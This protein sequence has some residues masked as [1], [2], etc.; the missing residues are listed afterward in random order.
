M[1]QEKE[2]ERHNQKL[3]SIRNAQTKEEIP[4]ANISAVTRYL[5]N[6]SSFDGNKV[7]PSEFNIVLDAILKYNFF[8][9]PEVKEIYMQVLKK[10]YPDKTQEEYEQ[11]YSQIANSSNISHY[12]IEASERSAKLQEFK[13]Q[14]ELEQHKQN[15]KQIKDAFEIKDLPKGFNVGYSNTYKT[16]TETKI[17]V[18]PC[19]YMDGIN[20][21]NNRDMF[22]TIDKLRYIVRDIKDFFKKQKIYIKIKDK[23][24]EIIGRIGTYHIICNIS[25]SD[26]K[27]GN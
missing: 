11:K 15:M 22:R 4:T 26:I 12:I 5:S 9:M 18:I 8:I 19:G 24:Y 2:L 20:I 27:I 3:Q 6:N 10:N 23:N 7:S 14:E 21:I 13:E 17:A 25:N 16:K 1:N